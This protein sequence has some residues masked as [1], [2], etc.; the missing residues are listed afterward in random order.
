MSQLVP[1]DYYF[2]PDYKILCQIIE[3]H[4]DT[5]DVKVKY[6]YDVNFTVIK[7]VPTADFVRTSTEPTLVWHKSDPRSLKLLGFLP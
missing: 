4:G 5:V 2:N 7:A 3:C 1:G 6:S